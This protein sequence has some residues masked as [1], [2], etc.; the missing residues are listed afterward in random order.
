MSLSSRLRYLLDACR[1]DILDVP[2][3]RGV[4]VVPVHF[5]RAENQSAHLV[6]RVGSSVSG[7]D[8]QRRK[9]ETQ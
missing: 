3:S 9:E 8:P 1:G 5:P 7:A 6:A 2:G 4:D